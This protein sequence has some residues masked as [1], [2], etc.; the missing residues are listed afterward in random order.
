MVA[1]VF[2]VVALSAELEERNATLPARKGINAVAGLAVRR[3]SSAA[4]EAF[5]AGGD[6][7]RRAIEAADLVVESIFATHSKEGRGRRSGEARCGVAVEGVAKLID[8]V[9]RCIK[10]LGGNRLVAHFGA[11]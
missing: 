6:K 5:W 3:V 8:E 11:V 1:G 4:L 7:P 10:M 9:G 2:M